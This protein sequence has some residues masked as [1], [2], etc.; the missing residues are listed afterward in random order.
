MAETW[1]RIVTYRADAGG[2]DGREYLEQS[3]QDTI[4]MLESKDGFRGGH[5]G[6]DADGDIM[7]AVTNWEDLE[8]IEAVSAE[9]AALHKERAKHGLSVH[10]SVNLKLITTP[11]AWAASDWESI[12]SRKASNWM[13]VYTYEPKSGKGDSVEHLR[14]SAQDVIKVLKGAKGFRL[15][16][17]G[18][19]P[20]TKTAAAITYWDSLENI[21]AA[22]P[23][24]DRLKELRQSAGIAAGSVVNLELLHTQIPPGGAARGWL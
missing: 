5:W 13:R 4:R 9:L 3:L 16:Y 18:Q 6:H 17:W 7:A 21:R 8:S 11:T 19:D 14:E 23:E 15:G 24:L 1:L 10:S 2:K 20:S 22:G 12:T